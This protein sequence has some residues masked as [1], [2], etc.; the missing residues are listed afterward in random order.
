[1]TPQLYTEGAD[2]TPQ[3]PDEIKSRCVDSNGR[4]KAVGYAYVRGSGFHFFRPKCCDH[5]DALTTFELL[6]KYRADMR[7]KNNT[8]NA[9]PAGLEVSD[10]EDNALFLDIILQLEKFAR[11]HRH[12]FFTESQHLRSSQRISWP[13]TIRLTTPIIQGRQVFYPS[14]ISRVRKLNNTEQLL[15][16]Y[17][18]IINCLRT[19][20]P[21]IVNVMPPEGIPLLP[22]HEFQSYIESGCG[23]RLLRQ[24]RSKYFSDTATKLW[25]LCYAYFTKQALLRDSASN[26]IDYCLASNFDP[27]FEH[28]IDTLISD[29]QLKKEINSEKRRLDHLFRFRH[30]LTDE[31]D[32]YYIVDSK[33]YNEGADIDDPSVFKQYDY[34]RVVMEKKLND[35]Y[36][37]CTHS[38]LPV[39]NSFIRPVKGQAGLITHAI[40]K[41]EEFAFFPERLFD[42]S[43]RHILTFQVNFDQ[44]VDAYITCNTA[45]GE[46][47][48]QHIC[49]EYR[50]FINARYAGGI[51]SN[52]ALCPL[53]CSYRGKVHRLPSGA[54]L[55][56]DRQPPIEH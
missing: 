37:P 2:A 43:T 35:L 45:V 50:N 55:M 30:P 5:E 16:I 32:G 40:T 42:P 54:I 38:F 49:N 27:I 20:Y 41:A 53:P 19:E 31:V 23:C 44:I 34:A 36:S 15:I 56:Y 47:I 14:P 28:M 24:I 39:I 25:N 17:A 21:H 51:I 9:C 52:I 13:R 12:F 10:S 46:Q 4:I 7:K 29:S 48:R 11:E 1:M 8:V 18:S 33:Y 22:P 26:N 3:L 6:Q